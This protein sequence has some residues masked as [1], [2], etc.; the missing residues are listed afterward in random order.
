MSPNLLKQKNVKS[1]I[2]NNIEY[3]DVLDIKKNH[4]DLKIDVREMIT[5]EGTK[6]IKAEHV[7]S[8]TDF[9]KTM[10]DIFKRNK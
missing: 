10:R 1:I 6:L 2:I 9:D 7:T 4:Q 8:L 5:I 3:F